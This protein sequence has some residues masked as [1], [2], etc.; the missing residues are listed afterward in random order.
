MTAQTLYQPQQVGIELVKGC[1]F[2][3]QMCPVPLYREDEAW[4]FMD[5]NLL[6]QLVTEIE[7]YDS[8]KTIWLVHFGEPLAHPKLRECF[9][10]LQRVHRKFPRKVILHT[11]ASLLKGEKVEALLE[12]PAVTD[13]TFS[14]DGFGDKESFEFLRGQHFDRVLANIQNFSHEAATRRPEL[15]LSTCSVVPKAEELQGWTG[16]I[17]SAE[18]VFENY[19]RLFEPLKITVNQRPMIDFSG[20]EVLPINSLKPERVF[21]GCHF[22]EMDSL[23]FAVSGKAQACCNVFNED[24]NVGD[25]QSENFSSLLNN[26]KMNELRHL[27]RLDQR[28]KLKYCHNCSQSLGRNLSAEQL[29]QFWV[30]RNTTYPL[31]ETEKQYIFGLVDPNIVNDAQLLLSIWQ[32]RANPVH[33]DEALS[34]PEGHIDQVQIIGNEL[35]ISGWAADKQDA[36]PLTSFELHVNGHQQTIKTIEFLLR[37]DVAHSF[38]R[39]DWKF[40]GFRLSCDLLYSGVQEIELKVS[41]TAKRTKAIQ[42]SYSV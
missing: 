26:S 28:D 2:S 29:L 32:R 4:Q 23:Y 30:K 33:T 17:P 12:I 36:S 22:V 42:A 37:S 31:S 40:S 24:F 8:I 3:C 9:Q 19:K 18:T 34:C 1:N 10:I 7:A 39:P 21:G 14:F 5:L 13:L 27:L 41:N 16:T 15:K 35:I 38:Q 6:E 20:N 25:F 11:N